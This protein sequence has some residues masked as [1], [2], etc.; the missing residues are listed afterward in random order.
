MRG[1]M[2]STFPRG[3][4]RDLLDAQSSALTELGASSD[5]RAKVL[6]RNLARLLATA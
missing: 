3:Y 2:P 5:D 1:T 6:G 4:R